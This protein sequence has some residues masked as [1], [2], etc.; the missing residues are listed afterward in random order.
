MAPKP[1]R[2]EAGTV[3][4]PSI[5]VKAANPLRVKS[6]NG[7]FALTFTNKNGWLAKLRVA[8]LRVKLMTHGAGF[9]TLARRSLLN[10]RLLRLVALYIIVV[11][12]FAYALAQT[13]TNAGS[14][15]GETDGVEKVG[16]RVSAP[17]LVYS[18]D[19]EYSAEAR[20]ANYEGFCVLSVVVGSDGRPHD[21]KVVQEL[22]H[23]LDE[24]AVEA[25]KEWKFEP[26]MKDGK[27]VAVQT[28]VQV[29]FQL[30]QLLFDSVP[31]QRLAKDVAQLNKTSPYT[32]EQLARLHTA[33]APF[34]NT[35]IKELESQRV[36]LPHECVEL[37][38]SMRSMREEHSAYGA[39]PL[40]RICAEKTPP[41]C[42]APPRAVFAPDPEYS[43]E[44]RDA[45]CQGTSVLWTIV[46]T[47]G[48]AHN[49][50]VARTL[51]HG[52]DENA[53]EAVK[54]WRF[55]PAKSEG[56]PVAVQLNIEVTF[57]LPELTVSP[58]SPQLVTGAKQQF[59]VTIPGATN[60]AVNWSVSG[61][62]CAASACGSIS[63]DG[64]YTAP[65]SVP[66]SPTVIVT[67]TSAT[68]AT[69][70]GSVM[71]TIQQ[72]PSP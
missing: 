16:G 38:E 18:P 45:H 28:Y 23:G 27:P 36:P 44:A 55:E 64:L 53:I 67:A 37:L 51:G 30:Q 34:M 60:C 58:A 52:L 13:N 5:V 6:V 63:S 32:P 35:T 49:T 7:V 48:R 12:L 4:I 70:K 69:K 8:F 14:K 66:N 59:S 40:V 24:K 22:G 43:Q 20:D 11:C 26:A 9:P 15:I 31:Q 39:A 29:K 54:Q 33:C 3:G 19:P 62:D 17:R 1:I 41:P 10:A 57:R 65:S 72:S 46:G 68:D 56:I 47:D 61:P 71:V 2:K 42:V 50:K 21:I 25:V